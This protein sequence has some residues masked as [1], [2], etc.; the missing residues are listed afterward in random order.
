MCSQMGRP[1][2]VPDG[3]VLQ[4]V[5]RVI[6]RRGPDGLTIREVARAAGISPATVLQRFGSRRGLL[7]AFA[8]SG[9]ARLDAA[10]RPRP[11]DRLEDVLLRAFGAIG[12]DAPSPAEMANHVAMLAMDL[13]D[14]GLRAATRDH[15]RRLRRGIA[16]AA[17]SA[18]A[19]G[20]LRAPEDVAGFAKALEAGCHGCLVQ[21]AVLPQ[22]SL[23]GA[24]RG[25]LQ[26]LTQPWR[27]P[28]AHGDP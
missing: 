4:A 21:W 16:A 22:G 13:R 17:R 6:G 12:P 20:E 19:R 25:T 3:A 2:K 24:L 10:F 8:S 1:K 18:V 9:V 7:R 11:R 23:E 5:A 26:V 15:F 14:P 28:T 27:R